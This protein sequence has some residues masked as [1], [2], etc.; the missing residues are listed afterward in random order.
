LKSA[1]VKFGK[2]LSGKAL[3]DYLLVEASDGYRAVF[4][5]PELDAAFT[6]AI[7][8]LADHRDGK[9]LGERDG[10]QRVIVPH[11]KRHARWVRG[12]IALRVERAR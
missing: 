9:P 10:A 7:V 6:D 4:V 1:G 2:G 12:V 5:L 11:E 8:L 3:G